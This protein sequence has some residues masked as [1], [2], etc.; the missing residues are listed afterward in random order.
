MGEVLDRVAKQVLV[1]DHGPMIAAAVQCDVDGIPEGSHHASVPPMGQ[2]SKE[3]DVTN[4]G[5]TPA[6]IRV[7]R[8]ESQVVLASSAALL[9]RGCQLLSFRC[10]VLES[11]P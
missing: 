7:P 4:T 11:L 9:P 5:V 1:R 8:G 2:T 3:H 10:G 6:A